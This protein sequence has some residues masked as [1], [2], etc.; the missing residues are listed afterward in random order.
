M[1]K[2]AVSSQGQTLESQVDPRFGRAAYFLVVDPETMDFTVVDN[3]SARQMGHGA[4]IQAAE[5]V[6]RAGAKTVIS[7]VV[8]PKAFDALRGAGLEVVQDAAGTVAQA[9]AAFKEGRLQPSDQPLGG[10]WGPGGGG[11]GMG[12]GGGRGMGRS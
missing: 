5:T 8:G 4:G 6:A 1:A 2:V 7:G 12:R 3:T 11:G 9:V 10:G